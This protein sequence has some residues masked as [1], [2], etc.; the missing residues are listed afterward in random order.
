MRNVQP[1]GYGTEGAPLVPP[2]ARTQG[3]VQ[4]AHAAEGAP[5]PA[6]VGAVPHGHVQSEE[7]QHVEVSLP[8]ETLAAMQE[9]PDSAALGPQ[10][11]IREGYKVEATDGAVGTVEQV[12]APED[13]AEQY[14]MVKEGL[15]FKKH[16]NVPFSAVDRV[17]DETVYL[18]IDK[19]YIRLMEGRDTV[20][21]GDS[22]ARLE[23]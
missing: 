1:D 22:S 7:Y 5:D 6:E 4:E 20:H 14:M 10:W 13:A 8:P 12:L 18:N 3:E 15:L 11:D 17:E 19:E 9:Q 23:L 16:V 2:E 21:T